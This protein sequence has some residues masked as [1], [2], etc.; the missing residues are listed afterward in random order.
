MT[1]RQALIGSR[2]GLHLQPAALFARTAA[3]TGLPVTLALPGRPP[4]DG[5]N[6]LLVVGL[7]ARCGQAVEIEVVG[8]GP[9]A[10]AAL[11]ALVDLLETDHDA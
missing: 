6:V 3:S 7:G 4:V 8:T 2:L 11:R 5:R 1:G 10:D 9:E